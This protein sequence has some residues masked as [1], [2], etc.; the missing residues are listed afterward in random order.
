MLQRSNV[1]LSFRSAFLRTAYFANRFSRVAHAADKA[2]VSP[3]VTQMVRMD[4]KPLIS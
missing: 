3:R 1:W 4:E 2:S